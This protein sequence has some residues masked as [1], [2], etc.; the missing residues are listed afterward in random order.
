MATQI[1]DCTSLDAGDIRFYDNY[2]PTL[3]VGDYLVN[4][5]QRL[6]PTTSPPI[7]ECY[8]TSQAFSVEG[9]RYSLPTNDVFSIYPPNNS[10]GIYDQFL[11]HVVLTQRELPWERNVFKDADATRQTPW[12]ALVLFVEGEKI[13]GQPALLPPQVPNWQTNRQ[14]SATIPAASL[15]THAAGDGILW[16]A[17]KQEWYE[18]DDFLKN[19]LTSVIDVSPQAFAT[20]VPAPADLRYLAHVRQVDPS[21]KDSDVLRMTGSGWYSVLVGNRLPDAPTRGS[22]L[23]GKRN[24]VHL[25][26]LEGLTSYL[27]GTALP[28]GTTRVR[29][30]SLQSWSFTCLPELG[31]SFSQIM[32]GLLKDDWGKA[33][34]TTFSLPVSPPNSLDP[35]ALYAHQAI[36]NGYVPLRYQTRLGEAT[37]AWYRGPFSPIPVTD[38]ATPRQRG[39]NDPAG[40][41]PFGTASAAMIYDKAY[42]VFDASYSVAWE[43]GR[44]LALSDGNFGQELL[45]FQRKGHALIDLIL[46]RKSQI[47]ALANFNPTNPDAA[48]EQSLLQLLQPYAITGDF[49]TYLVAQFSE[50]IA[51]KLYAVPPSLPDTPFP[52]Y[53]EPSHA[54][55]QSPD[56]CRSAPGVRR[57]GCDPGTWRP[58]A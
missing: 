56:H 26:S 53:P 9:P 54:A 18:S 33:K 50:Q 14:M 37:F 25:V 20:F 7:D 32:N 24:I 13:G 12:M 49:M 39:S 21:A 43:A 8:A 23:P 10:Q 5:T 45:D 31:E 4:V 58:G 34:S 38:F 11:P 48:T 6:N 55:S 35:N 1:D 42:G 3:G 52:A 2:V 19:T 51:P 28:A 46:E 15:Y 16:P 44:L 29:M 47:A 17:L 30:I 22:G 27:T 40:W 41:K 36:Q 57:P